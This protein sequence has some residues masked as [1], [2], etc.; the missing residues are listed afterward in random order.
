M[1][2]AD[3]EQQHG[4]SNGPV[5]D[6]LEEVLRFGAVVRLPQPV[7]RLRLTHRLQDLVNGDAG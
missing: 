5:G 6:P 2:D 7:P 4:F 3:D 1:A